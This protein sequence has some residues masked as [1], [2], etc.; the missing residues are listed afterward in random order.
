MR[1]VGLI[2]LVFVT[3]ACA[4]RAETSGQG[5][6]SGDSSKLDAASCNYSSALD[7]ADGGALTPGCHVVP[8]AQICQVSNGATVSP[9]GVTNGTESCEPVCAKGKYP[10]TCLSGSITGPI[11][12]P[13]TGL[14]CEYLGLPTASDVLSYCCQCG[15]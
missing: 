9:S 3:C 1:T 15:S 6:A 11:P 2:L 4:G 10:V 13:P 7:V 5:D 12:E 8:T 14:G